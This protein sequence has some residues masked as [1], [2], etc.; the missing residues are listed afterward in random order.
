MLCSCRRRGALALSRPLSAHFSYI[1]ALL[2]DIRPANKRPCA[3]CAR[4][5]VSTCACALTCAFAGSRVRSDAVTPN[6]CARSR[7]QVDIKSTSSRHQVEPDSLYTANSKPR[8]APAGPMC[9]DR[10][11]SYQITRRQQERQTALKP[12]SL[13]QRS[14]STK[15]YS[16][17]QPQ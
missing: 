4:A 17:K 7:H 13:D 15:R 12:L 8:V 11:N 9:S 2:H 16:F 1:V 10:Y 14:L 5:R 3:G 6:S